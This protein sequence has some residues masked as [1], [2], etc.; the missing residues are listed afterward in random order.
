MAAPLQL[1]YP[2]ADLAEI[3]VSA[4]AGTVEVTL[5]LQPAI[6]AWRLVV[7]AALSAGIIGW[8]VYRAAQSADGSFRVPRLRNLALPISIALQGTLTF[9]FMYW[10]NRRW[11]GMRATRDGIRL[12]LEGTLRGARYFPR[13]RIAGVLIAQDPATPDSA[14]L[15]LIVHRRGFFGKEGIDAFP[16]LKGA[17]EAL[18]DIER[19]LISVLDL[20]PRT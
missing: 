16:L 5:P 15:R 2:Q 8:L 7:W 13:D 9:L 3:H 18:A 12:T 10:R 11:R 4:Y 20:P 6:G 14:Y 1:Q 19:A 17:S